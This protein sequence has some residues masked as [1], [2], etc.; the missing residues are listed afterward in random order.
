MKDLEVVYKYVK[1]FLIYSE[2]F[3]K[4]K[5]FFFLFTCKNRSGSILHMLNCLFYFPG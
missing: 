2:M 4:T 1:S 3:Q 5:T